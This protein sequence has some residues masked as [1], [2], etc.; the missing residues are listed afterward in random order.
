MK[1][2]PNGCSRMGEGQRAKMK[3]PDESWV[4]RVCACDD[5]GSQN[6]KFWSH[7]FLKMELT[8]VH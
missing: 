1:R 5:L 3:I 7:T 8:Y 2:Q 6:G 4:V